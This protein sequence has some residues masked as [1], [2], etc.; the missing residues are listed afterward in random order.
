VEVYLAPEDLDVPES[1]QGTLAGEWTKVWVTMGG[2]IGVWL[3]GKCWLW[4]LSG[5][6]TWKHSTFIFN[7]ALPDPSSIY[8]DNLSDATKRLVFRFYNT[9]VS[10]SIAIDN[11]SITGTNCIKPTSVSAS[12]ITTNSADISWTG[13]GNETAWNVLVSPVA[14]TDFTAVTPT[15]TVFTASYSAA[16]LSPKTQYYV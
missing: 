7:E 1:W 14:V 10:G 15:A 3:D 13:S 8:N 16:G 4:S 12:N 5:Q 11:L 2:T 9:G 6:A